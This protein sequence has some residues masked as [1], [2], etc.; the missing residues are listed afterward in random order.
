M[1]V[2]PQAAH[3]QLTARWPHQ[4]H[5]GC[6]LVR[7]GGQRSLAV[8]AARRRPAVGARQRRQVAAA[9][10]LDQ[11]RP[12]GERVPG[13]APGQARQPGR[14]GGRVGG[15]LGVVTGDQDPWRRAAQ[16]RAGGP[17]RAGPAGA[18]QLGGF[19]RT[20]EAPHEQAAALP[21]R[22]QAEHLAYV[23]VGSVRLGVQVVPVVPDD[24]QPEV[25][26]GREHRGAGADHR[27]GRPAAHREPAPVALGRA[28]V[29]RQHDM[30]VAAE[31]RGQGVVDA[32][33]VTPVGEHH[34]RPAPA[35]QGGGHRERH[36][37]RPVG[38]RQGGPD[39][40]R[41]AT[42]TERREQAGALV[43]GVPRA[44]RRDGRRRRRR[45]CG[46]LRLD[47]G[48]PRRDRQPQHVGHRARIAG[49]HRAGQ[50]EDRR[51]EHG[52]GR[53]HL[54]D[55]GQAARMLRGRQPL[56]DEAADQP[57]GE[58]DPHANARLGRLGQ[59]RRHEVVERAVEVSQRHVEHHAGD[60]QVWLCRR[61]RDW[62]ASRRS[63]HQTGPSPARC[64]PGH[65]A[66]RGGQAPVMA[67]SA[68]TRSVRSQVKSASS[69]PKCP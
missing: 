42:G 41:G 63:S 49:G 25:L 68:S 6:A 23:R 44:G 40:A 14:A 47:P 8:P 69:R 33:H 13:R 51:A 43:V 48:V 24:H 3:S 57:S 39:G 58:P 7:G 64:S 28:E 4:A 38:T 10:H 12:A 66:P 31:A 9:G 27:A 16:H 2:P 26:H 18:D 52:L 32:G 62:L 61:V 35:G 37:V 56:G 17:H 34:Q 29:G 11:H 60:R 55:G 45:G 36:R 67:R 1:R 65:S 21:Q 54:G 22:A 30:A 53:H 5:A 20:G 46:R 15:L 19:R 50:V 59:R